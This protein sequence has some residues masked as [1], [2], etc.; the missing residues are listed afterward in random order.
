MSNPLVLLHG[1]SSNGEAFSIW[2]N[3][4]LAAGRKVEEISVGNYVTLNNEVTV[5]DIANGFHRALH[6]KGLDKVPFDA[7]VHSTGMLVLRS[8]LTASNTQTPRQGL[9]KHLVALAP[10]TF[11]SG[12]AAKGRSLLGRIFMG[13]RRI[14]PDFLDSGNLVLSN[15]ELGS[16]YTWN[17]AHKDLIDT[18]LYGVGN[19]TPYVFVFDGTND[20]GKLAE[21]FLPGDQKGSDGVVRWSGVALNTRKI[22]LNLGKPSVDWSEWSS[23]LLDIPL[24][25][26]VGLNHGQILSQPPQ[27]LIDLVLKALNVNSGD[28]FKKFHATDVANAQVVQQARAKLQNN[29]WQ[30]F[31]VHATDSHENPITDYSIEIILKEAD[32]TETEVANFESDVHPYAADTS[33]RCF[34]VQLDNLPPLGGKRLI[35]RVI[36]STGT[37][38]V[39]YQ[40]FGSKAAVPDFGPFDLD[41][42]DY[43]GT[44]PG[45]PALFY[46]FTTTLLEI[47]LNREPR[48]PIKIFQW[49]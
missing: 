18:K 32:G 7:M 39:G 37:E 17:L 26:V 8:W 1:Y 41:L 35:A 12:L 36:A 10:A 34:H 30:Q 21:I 6:D 25:P 42:S 44:K 13:N 33:Y 4:L 27:E 48:P 5:D 38:L 11:G 23:D 45:K 47:I 15:L 24:I 20:Y 2:K 43:D 22:T 9:L 16:A 19:D 49:L 3:A 31:V 46:P 40:G 14:G 29:R 28:D